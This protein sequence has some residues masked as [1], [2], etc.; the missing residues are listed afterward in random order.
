M[1]EGREVEGSED[2]EE[3]IG[4]DGKTEID[5]KSWNWEGVQHFDL[6]SSR[7]LDTSSK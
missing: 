2:V 1:G 6:Q 3:E 7:M 5:E 4:Q